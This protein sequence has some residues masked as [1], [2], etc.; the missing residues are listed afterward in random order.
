MRVNRIWVKYR[1]PGYREW[2]QSEVGNTAQE[3]SIKGRLNDG[4]VRIRR[5]ILRS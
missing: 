1:Q 5:V 2:P 3:D 4:R